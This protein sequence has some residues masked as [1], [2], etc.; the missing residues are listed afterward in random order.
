[1]EKVDIRQSRV[2]E[3]SSS[4]AIVLVGYKTTHPDDVTALA[5]AAVA[6]V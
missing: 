6:T 4:L 2:S 3:M 1:M 5:A